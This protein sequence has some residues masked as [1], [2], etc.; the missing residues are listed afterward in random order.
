M[1]G[2]ERAEVVKVVKELGPTLEAAGVLQPIREATGWL[3]A[4]FY[5]DPTGIVHLRGTVTGGTAAFMFRLPPGYRPAA[6]K[7]IT[8]AVNCSGV[9]CA[10]G[11]GEAQIYGTGFEGLG[12]NGAVVVLASHASLNGID[13]RA[14]S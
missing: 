8:F 1:T 7:F 11:A 10:N 2:E 4:A 6:E 9:L 14:E 12:L 5:K 3:P 13:F